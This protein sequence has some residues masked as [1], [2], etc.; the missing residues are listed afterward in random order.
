MNIKVAQLILKARVRSFV[1]IVVL[2]LMN[3]GLYVYSVVYLTPHLA[4]LQSKWFEQRQLAGGAASMD[5]AA[6]YRQGTIDLTAW[7]ARISP[8]NEFVRF[9][10][11]LFETS[12]RNKLKVGSITYKPLPLKEESLLAYSVDL[13]VS[14]NYASV[15][16]FIA[17]VGRLQDFAVIDNIAINSGNAAGESVDLRLQLTAYFR[18]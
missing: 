5:A 17:D 11:D 16:S 2:L 7:R 15:K 10:G 13:K 6:V 1:A 14:G 3:A 12:T 4:A 8:Q 18:V 9:V